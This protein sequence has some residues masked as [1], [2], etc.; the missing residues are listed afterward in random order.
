[1]IAAQARVLDMGFNAVVDPDTVW[2]IFWRCIGL[3]YFTVFANI[4]PQARPL[5]GRRGLAPVRETLAR[6]S[7][8]LGITRGV[9]YFPTLFWLDSTDTSIVLLPWAGMFAASTMVLFGPSTWALVLCWA[10]FLSWNHSCAEVVPFP[11]QVLLCEAGLLSAVGHA[12]S[13]N[14]LVP[15]AEIH[16][17][18][19]W[20]RESALGP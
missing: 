10:C 14:G 3:V 15:P 19:R 2:F 8:D 12:Y 16:W 20:L 11:W 5:R 9:L 17:M 6:V 4:A 13:L 7:A 1:M 18:M